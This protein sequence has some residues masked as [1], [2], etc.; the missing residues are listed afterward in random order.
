VG[1]RRPHAAPAGGTLLDP[2]KEFSTAKYKIS[3]GEKLLLHPAYSFDRGVVVG[4]TCVSERSLEQRDLAICRRA[5]RARTSARGRGRS[6]NRDQDRDRAAEEAH[7]RESDRPK[8]LFVNHFREDDKTCGVAAWSKWGSPGAMLPNVELNGTSQHA[9]KTR[10]SNPLC[11][12]HLILA[13]RSTSPMSLEAGTL[14]CERVA[15]PQWTPIPAE[16]H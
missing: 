9:G 10:K 15:L 3:P 7:N 12:A 2:V 14:G 4:T 11:V 1:S 16:G 5:L 8:G 6:R 13:C